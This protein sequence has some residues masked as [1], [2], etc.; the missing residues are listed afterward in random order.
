MT[1]RKR[2]HKAKPLGDSFV[3][4]LDKAVEYMDHRFGP[5]QE[6]PVSHF[7]V[8]DHNQWPVD[9]RIL[10]RHG[11]SDIRAISEHFQDILTEDQQAAILDEWVDLKLMIHRRRMETPQDVYKSLLAA[12]PDSIKNVLLLVE[13]MVT[14]SP[15]T[16]TVERGPKTCSEALPIK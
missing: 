5:M 9:K 8:F 4:A 10:L 7:E 16:A 11:E 13:I 12:R 3:R 6:P 14:L 15:S 2:H 1:L